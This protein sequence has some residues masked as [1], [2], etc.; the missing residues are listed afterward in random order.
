[1]KESMWLKNYE[2]EVKSKRSSNQE[3]KKKELLIGIPVIM[4]LIMG[5]AMVNGNSEAAQGQNAVAYMLPLFL[6]MIVFLLIVT[7]I[8]KKRM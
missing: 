7:S 2:Q 1:M 6:G 8:A 4:I 5:L 3:K